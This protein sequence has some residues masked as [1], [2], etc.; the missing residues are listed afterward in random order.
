MAEETATKTKF[1]LQRRLAASVLKSGLLKVRFDPERLADVQEAITRADI[2]RL[3]H[4]GIIT[5][6]PDTGISK[7]RAR[8]IKAQKSKGRRKGDGSR[9]GSSGARL[10]RKEDWMQR[11]RAQR[12]FIRELKSKGLIEKKTFRDMYRRS[13]GGFFRSRRH[14]NLYLT[15]NQ[16]FVKKK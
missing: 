7:F 14:I 3:I 6:R 10:G 15:E 2:K 16:L 11:V 5:A 12:E 9:K 13:K 1:D 4:D 8:K